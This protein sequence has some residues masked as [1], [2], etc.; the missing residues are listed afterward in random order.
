MNLEDLFDELL[1]Q[2]K[3][4]DEKKTPKK[5]TV[6][7]SKK[8]TG[9]KP[10]A[11]LPV[12]ISLPVKIISS[13]C[14]EFTVEK[15]GYKNNTVTLDMLCDHLYEMGYK[16]VAHKD[17]CFLPIEN[18]IV[19]IGLSPNVLGT[20]DDTQIDFN[21][22]TVI[23]SDG[24]HNAEYTTDMFPDKD[25]D[26]ISLSDLK[27]HFV[28]NN[29]AFEG[30]AFSYDPFSNIIIPVAP[31]SA[32]LSN[33]TA[34]DIN[35]PVYMN[36]VLMEDWL[37][38]VEN[39]SCDESLELD[40]SQEEKSLYPMA[41]DFLHAYLLDMYQDLEHTPSKIDFRLVK[42]KIGYFVTC[43]IT[44]G[45]YPDRSKYKIGSGTLKNV[46]EKY[47]LPLT[48]TLTG[49]DF[50]VD[51]SDFN[52]K[53]RVTQD[54]IKK[55]ISPRYSSLFRDPNRKPQFFYCEEMNHLEILFISGKKGAS[56]FS[57]MGSD[58]TLSSIH[59]MDNYYGILPSVHP[60]NPLPNDLIIYQTKVYCMVA[61]GSVNKPSLQKCAIRI[62][63]IPNQLYVDIIHWFRRNT[64]LE[65][66]VKVIYD[67]NEN[68]YFIQKPRY[69]NCTHVS[70]EYEFDCL[71][72]WQKVVLTIHSHNNMDA[73]FSMTDD[74]DEICENG[75][76][77]VMGRISD[78]H[79]S[80]VFRGCF[81]ASFMPL[82][83]E[84]L[85]EMEV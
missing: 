65:S 61:M 59:N 73:F 16:C 57:I 26:N 6:S 46:L 37:S 14:E 53:E 30:L 43:Q 42:T 85:F 58:D 10:Q 13:F 82:G 78:L 75:I 62:P 51:S 36:N 80:V 45:K 20:A 69:A 68:K 49:F 17:I 76:Y 67:F 64:R 55:F 48:I 79:P 21:G 8:E 9:K 35:K 12:S 11:K 27:K 3:K 41:K 40:D 38:T 52:G 84:D 7:K 15:I 18:G 2:E 50:T 74:Q 28:S 56:F 22:G 23:I 33:N 29:P 70:V 24:M 19:A 66:V 4:V 44:N 25:N 47:N 5:T 83:I 32:L 81:N 34:L 54:D 39:S 71:P 77:G 60:Q 31:I 72:I 1:G 63:H